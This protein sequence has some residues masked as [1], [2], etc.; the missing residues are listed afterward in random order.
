M[1]NERPYDG[2]YGDWAFAIHCLRLA[3][4][5]AWRDYWR[6]CTELYAY[7]AQHLWRA[8]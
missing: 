4:V 6:D 2:G 7:E 5:A 1:T 3:H 8:V